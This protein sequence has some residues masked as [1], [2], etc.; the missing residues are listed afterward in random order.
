MSGHSRVISAE[1]CASNLVLLAKPPD[2]PS[3]Q[4]PSGHP[5][6][7]DQA[8]LAGSIQKTP[9]HT[10]PCPLKH[11]IPHVSNL[12]KKPGGSGISWAQDLAIGNS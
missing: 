5:V 7:P 12:R 1:S 8:L 4:G 9:S 10:E 3:H 6:P 2:S 11:N